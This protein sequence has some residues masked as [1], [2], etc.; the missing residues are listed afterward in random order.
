MRV[1]PKQIIIDNLKCTLEELSVRYT[2]IDVEDLH[3]LGSKL[4]KLRILMC[5]RD[6]KG[7]DLDDYESDEFE[8]YEPIKDLKSTLPHLSI[9][10]EVELNI[11]EI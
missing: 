11:V 4:P 6:G 2:R 5:G 3:Q 10:E 1:Y 9:N 8:D 7:V